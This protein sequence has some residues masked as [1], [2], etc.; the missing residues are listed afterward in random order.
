MVIDLGAIIDHGHNVRI[1]ALVVIVKRIE[2][3]A[4]AVPLV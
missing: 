4:Q 2:E 1:V 3:H